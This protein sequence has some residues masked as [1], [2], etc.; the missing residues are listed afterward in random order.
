VAEKPGMRPFLGAGR[1]RAASALAG[2]G[3]RERWEFT[4]Q[5]AHLLMNAAE[6]AQKV[7]HGLLLMPSRERHI[8]PLLTRLES[9][10]DRIAV[11]RDVLATTNGAKIKARRR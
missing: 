4:K 8:R 7:N 9:D 6:F 11:W 3:R 1:S 2:V 10:N 5:Y